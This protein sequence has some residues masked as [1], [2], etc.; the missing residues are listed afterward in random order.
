MTFD[1]QM[2]VP[3]VTWLTHEQ[4]SDLGAEQVAG[5]PGSLVP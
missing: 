4:V 2:L 1:Q 3:N 5:D